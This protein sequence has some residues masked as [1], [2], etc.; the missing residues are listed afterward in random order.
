MANAFQELCSVKSPP[1]LSAV[2]QAWSKVDQGS[3]EI[4]GPEALSPLEVAAD[5][6]IQWSPDTLA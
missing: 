4:D 3:L 6:G 2:D 1:S 5:A